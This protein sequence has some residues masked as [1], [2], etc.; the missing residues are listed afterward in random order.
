MKFKTLILQVLV[1]ATALILLAA[2]A[3]AQQPQKPAEDVVRV[4]TDLVQSAFTVVDKDGHFVEGLR[5]DQLELTVDG[6][7]RPISFFERVTAGSQREYQ[8]FAQPGT[9][10]SSTSATTDTVYRGRTVIFFIDDLHLEP[11]SLHRTRDMLRQFI[12]HEMVAGDSVA[13]ASASGQLGF[14]QQ[15]TH[16]KEVLKATVDRLSP[17]PYDVRGYGTGSTKMSEYMALDID[18]HKSDDKVLKVFVEECMKQTN[19]FQKAQSALAA[20]RAT[21]ETQVKESARAVLMQS[22]NITRNMYESLYS[23]L[24]ST[25]RMPG[26]KLAFFVSDGFLM[27]VGSHGAELRDRLDHVID[28]AQRAGVVVYTIQAKGLVTSFPDAS[29]RQPVSERLDMARAG[30]EQAYQDALHALA[31]DTGGRA[32]RGTNYFDRWVSKMLDETSNYY[33]IA[34]RPESDQEKAPRFRQV[35]LKV[36]GRPELVARAPRGYVEGPTPAVAEPAAKLPANHALNT[37]ETQIRD[38]L[39]DYY[40]STELP[41][42][43]SLTYLNTPKNEML[44]NSSLQIGTNALNY[45]GDGN[46]PATVKV[47]GVILNDKGKIAGSFKNQLNVTPMNGLSETAGVIYNEHTPLAPGIY[48]VR[49]AARDEKSGR[50]G[51]ANQ[52]IV[53][54]DLTRRQLASSSI[55]LGGTVI[56]SK[57]NETA[58]VQLSVDHRFRSTAQLGYWIFIYNA[59]RTGVAPQL[60]VQSEV[61]RNGQVVLTGRVRKIV[62]AGADPNRIPFGDELPLSSLPAG[63]YDLNVIVKDEISGTTITQQTDFEIH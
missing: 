22:G 52:W 10:I 9:A 63:K 40:P 38:A 25:S 39:G 61:K 56:A 60:T 34:W 37:A 44:L 8:V 41:V 35:K 19:N 51:S 5:Q 18:T 15:F 49:A 31:E 59:A 12:D 11:D 45:G 46:Q 57:S 55:L 16:N 54:P 27:D 2:S 53:I 17:V 6:R 21:C 30:E 23:L 50:L 1:F 62:E 14:L 3:S 28:S 36:I 32:L 42:M 26:R 48:Q 58:Q 7:P 33:V 24:K 43:L 13:L 20:L 4:S 29:V 47:A